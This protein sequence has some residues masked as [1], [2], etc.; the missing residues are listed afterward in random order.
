MR[1]ID[2]GIWNGR[3]NRLPHLAGSIVC[4]VGWGRRFGLPAEADFYH[5]YK[6]RKRAAIDTGT[7]LSILKNLIRQHGTPPRGR[8]TSRPPGVIQ[9][10]NAWRSPGGLGLCV[11]VDGVRGSRPVL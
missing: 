10:A 1:S 6:I 8:T 5:S 4:D 2:C 3:R 11:R 9:F 7:P